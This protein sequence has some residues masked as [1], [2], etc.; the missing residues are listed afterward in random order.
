MKTHNFHAWRGLGGKIT[1][2]GQDLF[3]M[4]AG[5][6]ES[7]DYV[8]VESFWYWKSMAER[9]ITGRAKDPPIITGNSFGATAALGFARR[10]RR[11]V[12]LAIL[13]DASEYWRLHYTLWGTGGN[14]VPNNIEKCIHFTKA[15]APGVGGI[16]LTRDDGSLRG[17]ENIP[18]NTL[19]SRAD[20]H[21]PSIE[22]AI[23]E[24]RLVTGEKK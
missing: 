8:T 5:K 24:I 4:D 16:N 17:I 20:D 19:H 13:F 23:K 21:R 22:R 12:P 9:Y 18:I 15:F 10:I 3:A 14:Y 1:S 2:S 6:L 11:L 7:I